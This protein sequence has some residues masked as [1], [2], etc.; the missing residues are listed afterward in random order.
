MAADT[1]RK[2][3]RTDTAT[4]LLAH[5]L[6]DDSVFER[7]KADHCQAATNLQKLKRL[8]QHGLQPAELVVD[9]NAKRLKNTRRRVNALP[10]SVRHR[11]LYDSCQLTS[12]AQGRSRSLLHNTV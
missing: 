8:W 11:L 1:C 4:S 10:F 6:L 3:G 2:F 5:E 7:V 9:G 12:R